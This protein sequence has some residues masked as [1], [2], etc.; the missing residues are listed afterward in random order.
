MTSSAAIS[1]F[2]GPVA[3]RAENPERNARGGFTDPSAVLIDAGKTDSQGIVIVQIA[4]PNDRHILRDPCSVFDGIV[5]RTRRQALSSMQYNFS[6]VHK[7]T[8]RDASDGCR[9]CES[10]VEFREIAG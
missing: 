7:D 4:A 2:E 9:R 3:P 6:R 5:H 8:A 1:P 10:R